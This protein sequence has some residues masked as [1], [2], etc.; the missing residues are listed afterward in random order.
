MRYYKRSIKITTRQERGKREKEK[1]KFEN[2]HEGGI[3]T[4]SLLIS[5]AQ[6]PITYVSAS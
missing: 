1:R 5:F 4:L 2:V 6:C 3:K